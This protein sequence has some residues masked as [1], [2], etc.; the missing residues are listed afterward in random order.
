MGL[1]MTIDDETEVDI[2]FEQEFTNVEKRSRLEQKKSRKKGEKRRREDKKRKRE[3]KKKKKKKNDDPRMETL[4]EMEDA[5]V[6]VTV[7]DEIYI[8][9]CPSKLIT[10]NKTVGTQHLT[11]RAVYIKPEH[12]LFLER[13]CLKEVEGKECIF[14]A[15]SLKRGVVTRCAQQYSYSQA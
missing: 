13:I 15:R 6:M 4:L 8:E 2:E 10:T 1:D 14:P 12:S 11:N 5:Q 7:N 3:R 9:C